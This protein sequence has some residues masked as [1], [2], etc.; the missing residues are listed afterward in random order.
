MKLQGKI[1]IVAGIVIVLIL[2][3]WSIVTL[4]NQGKKNDSNNETQNSIID[5]A[6][7]IGA[8]EVVSRENIEESF[9]D[10]AKEIGQA[11][12]SGVMVSDRA[13]L[14]ESVKF[15]MKMT[16]NDMPADLYAS[17][18]TYNDKEVLNQNHPITNEQ[19]DKVEGLGEVAKF[20]AFAPVSA[21]WRAVLM[22][23]KDKTIY[24]FTLIQNYEK[25]IGITETA[26]K[27][28]LVNLAGKAKFED[29]A[30]QAK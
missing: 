9:K 25:G 22:V 17:K 23:V 18:F 4:M 28:A 8:K 7:T 1:F 13:L 24:T 21:D 12:D 3:G 2:I 29:K 10:L 15:A 14:A 5:T 19:A 16:K 26:A 27:E 20:Y 11:E 30:K 6:A